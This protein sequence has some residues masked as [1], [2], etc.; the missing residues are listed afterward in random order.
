VETPHIAWIHIF[1]GEVH[2]TM[3]ELSEYELALVSGGQAAEAPGTEP[4][5]GPD[6]VQEGDFQGEF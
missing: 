5:T 4:D 3:R 1:Q 2:M 6:V